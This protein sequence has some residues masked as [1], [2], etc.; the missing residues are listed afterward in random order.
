MSLAEVIW[1]ATSLVRDQVDRVAI[2]AGL[3]PSTPDF[4]PKSIREFRPGFEISRNFLSL[5]DEIGE[6]QATCWRNNLIR[7]A[8]AISDNHLTFFS[9][10]N[11][12]VGDPPNWHY[13][14]NLQRDSSTKAIQSINYRDVARNGDC[15]EVW[16]PNRHH[17]FVV[18][19]RAY[20]ITGDKRYADKVAALMRSWIDNNAFA[21][22]MN[23]RSPLELGVRMINWVW[24]LELIRGSGAVSDQLWDDIQLCM[25]RHCWDNQRKYSRG[26]SANNHLVGEAAGVYV[27]ASYFQN[28][29][30]AA[31]W[32][33][34]AKS[35]LEREIIAQSYPDGCTREQ[36]LGYQFFVIQ[37]YLACGLVGR[38][39]AKPFSS[40]YWSRLSLM[41]EF[42]LQI[43]ASG[44][45]PL[46]G[47]QDDG[48]VLDFGDHPRDLGA[49]ATCASNIPELKIDCG[50]S[51]AECESSFW[52]TG[53]ARPNADRQ[54]KDKN[55]SQFRSV[56][57][58]DAGYYLLRS[59]AFD[60]RTSI[61]FD[62]AELGYGEIAAHGHADALSFSLSA[63]GHYLIVDTGTYDY[64]TDIRW[65]NY[66]RSTAA[67]NTVEIDGE[68]QSHMSGPF[69]WSSRANSKCVKWIADGDQTEV[70]GQHDGY[71]R[72]TDPVSH[73]RTIS[74]MI[75]ELKIDVVDKLTAAATH[76]VKIYFHLGPD[77]TV[78]DVNDNTVTV[79]FAE[80]AEF[81]LRLDESLSFSCVSGDDSGLGWYSPG[82]HRKQAI[83]TVV[84]SREISGP[85][86]LRHEI[87]LPHSVN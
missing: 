80:S 5:Q 81:Q 54:N 42:P 55:S 25:F 27:A 56:A 68:N 30:R 75:D 37:F 21:T 77:C 33:S 66:F 13:D 38:L 23:W 4:Q 46:F 10:V 9:H 29:P 85:V 20:S 71:H 70:Q 32:A 36:A 6:D 69:M 61:L 76:K 59:N 57:F 35:I 40:E 78:S 86:E 16:E 18:L 58:A 11:L 47:D 45:L 63:F 14:F 7:A 62:C 39:T 17:Q 8:D 34:E 22:G 64:F 52:W 24:A 87:I 73:E 51:G 26:S 60:S 2:P 82:Y 31:A 83:T 1:R 74:L 41:I 3:I 53:N 28:F 12:H 65:R 19:A 79:R 49:L 43:G 50:D 48:Y 15:K 44:T 67:H 72:L 84:A